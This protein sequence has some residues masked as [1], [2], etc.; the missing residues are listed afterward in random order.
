[1]LERLGEILTV[2]RLL[3]L[4]SASAAGR[5]AAPKNAI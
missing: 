5:I 2:M 3:L 1:M 4:T